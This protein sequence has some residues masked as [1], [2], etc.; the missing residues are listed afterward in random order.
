MWATIIDLDHDN[1]YAYKSMSTIFDI[2][3]NVWVK[4]L[5]FVIYEHDWDYETYIFIIWQ[6]EM[7]RFDCLRAIQH[8]VMFTSCDFRLKMFHKMNPKTPIKLILNDYKS[9]NKSYVDLFWVNMKIMLTS[10][11]IIQ[12]VNITSC[13][14]KISRHLLNICELFDFYSHGDGFDNHFTSCFGIRIWNNYMCVMYN[15]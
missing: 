2:C 5:H 12:Q 14:L 4:S 6:S 15:I 13:L 7:K 10:W 3:L 1:S 8:F 9:Y 11:Q